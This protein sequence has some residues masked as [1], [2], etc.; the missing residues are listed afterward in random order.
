VYEAGG[1]VRGTASD[2]DGVETNSQSSES[3]GDGE[4]IEIA[5]AGS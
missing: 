1:T 5:S 3:V 4:G 2:L